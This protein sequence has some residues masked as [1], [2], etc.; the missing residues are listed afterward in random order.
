MIKDTTQ[1]QYCQKAVIFSE[2]GTKVL[3][4]K[5]KGEA[6]FDGTYS[7]VCGKMETTDD[8][9]VSGIRREIHEEL[10]TNVQITVYPTYTV[11]VYYTKKDGNG[12]ILPHIFATYHG[13]DIILS[14]EY[15]EYRWV[16]VADLEG[17][18]PKIH[19]IPDIVQKLLAAKESILGSDGIVI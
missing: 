1:F 8:S 14:D 11:N 9:I 12:M 5:R 6:D 10:G 16:P 2:D 13:G 15:S 4:A 7:F 19:T 3:L 18:E 17:F